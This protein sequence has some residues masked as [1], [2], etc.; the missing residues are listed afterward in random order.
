MQTST[1]KMSNNDLQHILNKSLNI[2][3]KNH[4]QQ[5]AHNK[6]NEN[7]SYTPSVYTLFWREHTMFR[8]SLN[9]LVGLLLE[10]V[11]YNH[12]IE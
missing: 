8:L 12:E 3:L 5:C 11:P 2:K 10:C 7:T 9:G 1:F 6:K 4:N